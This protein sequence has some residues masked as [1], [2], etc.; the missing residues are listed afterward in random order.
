[1]EQKNDFSK[2]SIPKAIW[3]LALPMIAAQVINIL[4][5]VVDRMYLGHM[6]GVGRLALTGLGI[7]LPII[8]IVIA[9]AN[10]CGMGGAPLC[11]IHR[12]KG[13]HEEAERIL[14]N[15][16][17][18]L[19]LFGGCITALF[20]LVKKPVLYLFG[21][22]DATFG[23]ADDYLTIYLLGTL[24]VMIGLGLNP[25]INSQGF[26]KTGMMTV[27]LGAVVNIILDPIFIFGLKL[28]V[29]G[30]ALATILA[31]T[32]SAVWVLRFL[33]GEKA[34]LRL[35]LSTMKLQARRVRRILSLGV[36][37]F[38]MAMTNS[39]VQVLCNASLQYYGGDLYVGVMTVLNS[40]REVLSMPAQ[41]FGN[42]LQPV[43]GFNYGAKEYGRVREGIRFGTKTS[44]LYMGTV[45]AVIMLFPQLFIHIFNSE[46]QLLEA[47]VPAMRMYFS[48]FF[49]FGLQ[50]AGQ[51]AFVALGKA[52]QAS[53]FA[54]FRKVI[55]LTPFLLLL[56]LRIGVDGVF[57]A[58]SLSQAIGGIACYL[59]M[60]FT[61]YRPL[62]Q[63]EQP[64][65]KT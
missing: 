22:S 3:S 57:W 51:N 49:I 55:V 20:L 52:K 65:P 13:E 37:G 14:G 4:Y 30:A 35:R 56:P 45:W 12:G 42:G 31:Q 5:S 29:R 28:G 58:E 8:S 60:Y 62:G 21:A 32:C 43:L 53:F 26:G 54:V 17:T 33:T 25:F 44:I 9:F 64:Q 40:V 19:L 38:L 10:L 6:E 63:L 50:M 2:G 16:F 46:A 34:I 7:C 1:M 39:L 48:A 47:G 61:V 15:S 59:T 24:S 18:L 23:Y 41:G 27:L 11:S 36:S